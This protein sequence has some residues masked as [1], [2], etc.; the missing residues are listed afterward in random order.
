M[1]LMVEALLSRLGYRTTCVQRP[2]EAISALKANPAAF[3]VVVT[4]LNMPDLSGVELADAIRKI[5]SDLPVVIS[6][7][8]LIPGITLA[9]RR[10]GVRAVMRKQYTLEEIGQLLRVVLSGGEKFYNDDP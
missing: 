3:D 8:N 9:A 6:S 2:G 5:R 7:G 4:D 10:V 1:V